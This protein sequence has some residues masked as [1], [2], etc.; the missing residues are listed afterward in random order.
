M[1]K[2][3]GSFFSFEVK[4]LTRIR[5]LLIFLLITG[6]FLYLVQDGINLYEDTILN[7]KTFQEI[8]KLKVSRITNMNQYALYG[9]RILFIPTSLSVLFYNSTVF[10]DITAIINNSERLELYSPMKGKTLFS[11]KPGRYADF[12]GLVYLI[13]C[14]LS[15]LYGL[16][17]FRD[18]EYLK[19]IRPLVGYK[20]IFLF[21]T[22]TRMIL[23]NLVFLF[24]AGLS[25]VWVFI[26]GIHIFN[27]FLLLY[28]ILSIMLF[29][30]FF[31]IGLTL[32]SLKNKINQLIVF[33]LVY[34]AL[35]FFI[36]WTVDKIIS[37]KAEMITPSYRLEMEKLDALIKFEK[38]GNESNGEYKKEKRLTADERNLIESFWNGE[39]MQMQKIEERMIKEIEANAH[40]FQFYSMFLPTSYYKSFIF[41]IG[42]RGF[43]GF[44][45][46]YKYTKEIDKQ[47][48]RF[49]LDKIYYS[50]NDKVESFVKKGDENIFFFKSKLPFTF[51]PGFLL[52]IFYT[53]VALLFAFFLNGKP[54][55]VIK[56]KKLV[57]TEFPENQNAAYFILCENDQ[58]KTEVFS[59][60]QQQENASCLEKINTNDFQFFDLKPY[61][62]FR[63]LCIIAGINENTAI[64][65]LELLGIEDIGALKKLSHESFLKMCAAVT[66]SLDCDYFVINDFLKGE[67]RRFE[68]SFIELLSIESSEKRI[69]YLSCEMYNQSP[70]LN[71][72]IMITDYKIFDLPLKS[73]SVR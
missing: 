33:A 32:S 48:M 17:T 47:F 28:I 19:F 49:Y 2:I 68:K 57:G 40:S 35:I 46:Y 15:C 10:S 13:G 51:L 58:V 67:S 50:D 6:L 54:F 25:L 8:E 39:F 5:N 12:S 73:V 30:F 66:A 34:I 44:L 63:H 45:E 64:E 22:I 27:I 24:C 9:F 65:K 16:L 71:D 56:S 42:S 21:E 18:K 26:K 38:R 14:F 29:N 41:E 60:F 7:I 69:I 55:K 31:A 53:F 37:K 11:E 61:I 3:F 62:V 43:S 72:C 4:R 59:H 36:P 23:L 1:L 70:S 20:K 52:T